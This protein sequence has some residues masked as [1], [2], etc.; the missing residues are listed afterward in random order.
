MRR[1]V[2]SENARNIRSIA[3]VLIWA[4]AATFAKA[5]ILVFA[6]P[7]KSLLERGGEMA[8]AP[9]G[10]GKGC[11]PGRYSLAFVCT[12]GKALDSVVWSGVY[13]STVKD[14]S[15]LR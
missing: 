10:A 5:N 11:R 3:S 13:N 8:A 4:S 12:V 15:V 9:P 6:I 7:V 2:R 14:R 1:R